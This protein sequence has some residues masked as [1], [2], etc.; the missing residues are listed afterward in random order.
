MRTAAGYGLRL[1]AEETKSCD[2]SETDTSGEGRRRL[3][4]MFRLRFDWCA[5]RSEAQQSALDAF[6]LIWRL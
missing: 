4:M 6:C 5:R 1:G 3:R 2:A